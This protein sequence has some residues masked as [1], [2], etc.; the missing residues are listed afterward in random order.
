MNRNISNWERWA[1]IAA[2]VG[3]FLLPRE[4]RGATATAARLFGA[5]LVF[6]G[7]TGHCPVYQ[8]ANINRGASDT[9]RALGGSAGVNV[10]HQVTINRPISEVYEFWHDLENLAGVMT[11]LESVQVTGHNRSH[12]KARGPGGTS[13][14]WDAET[15]NEVPNTLIAW[16]SLE[17]ADVVS[18]GSVNFRE[19]PAGRGTEVRVSL[20]YSPPAGKLG[21]AIA[22]L[23]GGAAEQQIREDLRN[24]K[25]HLE[26]SDLDRDVNGPSGPSPLNEVH[27]VR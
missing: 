27:S 3:L 13:V 11:H 7:A 1:S 21:A 16:R 4:R 14:S 23:F 10:T 9:R 26:T 15:I 20:Q 2:G 18:A 25:R 19:A 12:W 8:K 22:W 5:G 24:L 17:N 6:R